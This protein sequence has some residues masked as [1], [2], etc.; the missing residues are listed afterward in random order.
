MGPRS[1]QCRGKTSQGLCFLGSCGLLSL[2]CVRI[3]VSSVLG[4]SQL[5]IFG[6]P[7][8]EGRIT[9]S[10]Y[11]PWHLSSRGLGCHCDVT[12][13]GGSKNNASAGMFNAMLVLS[14]KILTNRSLTS[15]IEFWLVQVPASSFL[16]RARDPSSTAIFYN[17]HQCRIADPVTREF[18]LV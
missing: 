6:N 17:L 18:C 11:H 15:L 5:L 13:Q 10:F 4:Q 8:S 16:N 12:V 2:G 7:H 3:G 1:Q 9:P 14:S